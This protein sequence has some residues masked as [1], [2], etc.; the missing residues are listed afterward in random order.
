MGAA[1]AEAGG[2]RGVTLQ[3]SQQATA[4][5]GG[6]LSGKDEKQP[7]I[8]RMTAF[9]FDELQGHDISEAE[10]VRGEFLA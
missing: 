4:I 10:G 7:R 9:L 3:I 2:G 5:R 8:L 6:G 1:L